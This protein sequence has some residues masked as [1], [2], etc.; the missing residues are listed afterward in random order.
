MR[1]NYLALALAAM[2]VASP[3]ATAQ[4]ERAG[5]LASAAPAVKSVEM[6]REEG[7]AAL[8]SLDYVRAGAAFDDLVRLAPERPEGYLFRATNTWFKSLFDRRLL[9]LSLYSNDEFYAQK[10]KTVDPAVDKAFRADIQKAVEKAEVILAK[11]PNDVEALYYLGAAHGSLGGYEASMA[12]AFLSALKHGSK[13]VDLHEKV[14]K[15]DPKF[16]D[17]YLT[18]GMYHYVV[19]SLPFFVKALAAVGGVRG[20]K[21]QGLQELERVAR[22]GRRTADDARVILVGLYVREKRYEDALAMVRG[23]SARYPDNYLLPLE[24]ANTLVKLGKLDE[25]YAVYDRLLAHPRAKVEARDFVAFSYGEAL[26]LGGKYERAVAQYESVWG[27]KG[28][29]ADLV[30]LARLG[31]GQSHDALGRRKEAVAHYR[32][33]SQR[34]DVLDSR[35]KAARYAKEPYSPSSPIASTGQQPSAS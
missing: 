19:G 33:V 1:R 30:T 3:V 18:V 5:A 35:K 8:Y 14:L 23:L 12:R 29:D 28:A 15:L 22:E 6:L 2:L 4:S 25:A 27:F 21:K 9:S 17:A 20:S 13:S 31:A 7:F 11:S 24:E 26:R 10:E 16:A 32:V 34:A